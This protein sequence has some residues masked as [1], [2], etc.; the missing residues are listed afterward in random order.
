VFGEVRGLIGR[1]EGAA[2]EDNRPI[3]SRLASVRDQ[4]GGMLA[5]SPSFPSTPLN[6]LVKKIPA[7]R[8]NNA[9]ESEI[10]MGANKDNIEL[11][12]AGGVRFAD[13]SF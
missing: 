12:R 4:R 3:T 11:P 9:V 5:I 8:C 13:I 10:M 6:R 7:D 2:I 1:S